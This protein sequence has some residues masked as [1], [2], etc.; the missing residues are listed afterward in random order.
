MVRDD[1]LE[2]T[3]TYD[4]FGNVIRTTF[5]DGSYVTSEFDD[6]GRRTAETS[7]VAANG[8]ATGPTGQ[9]KQFGYDDQGRLTSV[10]L[11]NVI[12]TPLPDGVAG[13][14]EG[15]TPVYEYGY[16]VRGNMV[17][18]Q[19]P[20]ERVTWFTFDT[21]G[22]QLT[23]TLPS[24]VEAFEADANLEDRPVSLR[25][26]APDAQRL[27]FTEYFQYDDMGRQQLHVSFEGIVTEFVY[28]TVTGRL[29]QKRF[30]TDLDASSLHTSL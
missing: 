29:L 14:A 23:R 11:P 7:Q 10:T 16:D 6:L 27:T 30:Y 25:F 4:E 1:A 5:S 19:D 8:V 26:P 20:L 15:G 18:I 24:G 17:S 9:R 13:P 3:V 22:R 21:Q 28:S 2:S 12:L